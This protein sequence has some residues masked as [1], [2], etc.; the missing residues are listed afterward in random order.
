MIHNSKLETARLQIRPFCAEDAP[1]MVEIFADPMVARFVGEG[2]SLAAEEAT[3]W[4]RNSRA[5]LARHGNGTGAVVERVSER[6]IGW[7]GI[8]RPDDEEPEIIYGFERS[9]WGKGFGTELLAALIGYARQTGL[10]PIRATVYSENTRS[11][12]LLDN[13]GFRLADAAWKEDPAIRLY[14]LD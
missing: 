14:L 4:M 10:K 8:A 2:N 13:A 5:N 12:A 11:I 7:A 9:A 1:R 3:L 6:V